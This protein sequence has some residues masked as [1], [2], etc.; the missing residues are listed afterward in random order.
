[1]IVPMKYVS[2]LCM[3]EDKEKLL[4]AL[5]KC[6]EIM[7]E[8]KE[9][10]V[11]GGAE[12]SEK[13][14][15]MEALMQE[16]R[17]YKEKK[18]VFAQPP[19]VDISVFADEAKKETAF[20]MEKLAEDTAALE[21]S[22][23][24]DK[25]L[26]ERL[27][28]WKNLKLPLDSQGS[29]K[30]AF[31]TVG[32]IP[33]KKFED[34]E[35]K[36][37]NIGLEIVSQDENTVYAA[38]VCEKEENVAELIAEGFKKAELPKMNGTAE[39]NIKNIS[40]RIEKN[41]NEA[42]I[43]RDALKKMCLDNNAPEIMYNKYKAES[44]RAQ[45]PSVETEETALIEGWVPEDGVERLEKTVREAVEVYDLAVREPKE[46][47]LPPTLTKNSRTVSQFEGITNMFNPPKYGD[48][49]PNSVMAPW[50]WIIFGLMMGDAGYG[51]MM[52]VI[53]GIMKKVIKPKGMMLQLMN[54]F[55]YSSVTTMI[56]G[57]IFGSY[58]G[59]TWNPLL[60]SVLDNPVGMLV[61]TMAIGV[62]HMF[63]GMIV[64]IINDVKNGRV[65]D[66]LFDQVSWMFIISGI[67][68]IFIPGG[69]TAGIAMA[70]AGALVVLF[71]AGR[72]KKGF[73]GKIT[74]GLGGLYGI[75][76][77]LSDILSYSRIMALSLATGVVGMVMNMLA[78]MVQGSVIGFVISLIIYAV[79]HIF[80]LA[81]GLL[82]AYVHDCR[83]QYIEFYGKFY[84]G[85]GR[86]FKPFAIRTNYIQIKENGGE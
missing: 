74:G 84:E 65:L 67:G 45:A 70:A 57:I 37:K 5:Q 43:K 6:G 11:R 59:E 50:Y 60:F 73:F 44:E 38:V 21:A 41:I 49:D 23:E 33:V 15:R 31:Y 16:L 51:L 52:A 42:K 64:R 9:E 3:K 13:M 54:V 47:E 18:S 72:N 69:K 53:I 24:K 83:L 22:A 30:Y 80:N 66:A 61:L 86:L 12:A 56:C 26:L 75:T 39:E 79:G 8:E 58:F 36:F 77:Y 17:K 2:V 82:S 63:T 48:G 71:T 20:E 7:L 29:S 40:R 10:S 46:N 14:R 68:L 1:M 19:Q 34:C 55:L 28:P 25:L 85:G 78:G 35:K 27:I 4:E 81:L 32:M 76:G 62:A